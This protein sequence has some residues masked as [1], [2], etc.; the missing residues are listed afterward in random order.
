MEPL[1]QDNII[2]WDIGGANLKAACL[3]QS[4]NVLAVYQEYCPLWQGMQALEQALAKILAK[5]PEQITQHAITMTGELVDLFADRA[6]GVR[7]I[8]ALMQK[9]L[10][11]QS[12]AV[13][14]GRLG[15]IKA[16]DVSVEHYD[17]IAS[18]NWLASVSYVAELIEQG[19]FVDI[20]STTTDI[21]L[22]QNHQV[23]ALG[24]TDFQR[25]TTGELVYT[26]L[27]RTAVM[28]VAQS[29][30]FAGNEVG[31]M[32]EY[33]ATMA[34]VYR[35]T[36]ELN[37]QH[38]QSDTA[39]GQAKTIQASAQRLARMLGCDVQDFTM[40]QWQQLAYA[41]REQQ[42][43]RIQQASQKILSRLDNRENIVLIGAGVGRFL[44]QAVAQRLGFAYKDFSELFVAEFAQENSDTKAMAVADCA[45]AVCVAFL[46]IKEREFNNTGL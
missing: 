29:V 20:G 16:A 18:A 40:P 5:L 39:D 44:V 12:I 10:S 9:N 8:I 34:D 22:L 6:Q 3:N 46:A 33:F 19:L 28:A 30:Y 15:F 17:D 1:M 23:N 27:V 26:G 32:S 4:G 14:A 24:Y 41:I 25:L 2:G 38:D 7:A 36:H 35:L 42:L 13:Y 37:E 11:Q 45:P 21:I 43:L 31:L